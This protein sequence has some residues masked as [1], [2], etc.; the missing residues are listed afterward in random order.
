MSQGNNQPRVLAKIPVTV[1]TGFLGSGKTTL[2]RTVLASPEMADTAVIINE[3]GEVGLDHLLLEA[4]EEQVLELP[5]GCLCCVRRLDIVTTIR[6][7]IERRDRGAIRGFSRIVIET[8]GLADP[9]PILYTLAVDPTLGHVLSFTAVVTLV[10]AVAGY[11]SLQRHP[12][13]V[14]QVAVADRIL[15]TKID[16]SPL[17][18]DLAAMLDGLNGWAERIELPGPSEPVEML[19][20][21]APPVANRRRFIAQ[22]VAPDAAHTAAIHT[23]SLV[24][25]EPPTRF[26]FA[27]ALGGLAADRG[28]D[29]LRAK[30][31]LCFADRPDHVA[32][33]HAVQHTIYRPEWLARWPDDDARSRLVFITRDIGADDILRRFA[34]FAPVPWTAATI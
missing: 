9:A 2:L 16:L 18:G 20:T 12:E 32:V 11:T 14:S 4:V 1:L 30:G 7:L 17:A 33:I 34:A 10:D 25:A 15:I 27:R 5:S 23:V 24:L 8:S 26:A 3:A 29:L 13:A 28:A 21:K 6:G 31:L 19:F 22:A